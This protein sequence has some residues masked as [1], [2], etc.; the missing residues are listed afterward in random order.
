MIHYTSV[1]HPKPTEKTYQYAIFSEKFDE[2]WIFRSILKISKN[3]KRI[4]HFS[5][6]I[7]R[8]PTNPNPNPNPNPKP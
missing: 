2:F 5:V 7:H 1:L 4:N 6:M 8:I 3:R